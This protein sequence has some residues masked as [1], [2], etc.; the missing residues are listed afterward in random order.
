MLE[1]VDDG[2]E[3]AVEEGVEEVEEVTEAFEFVEESDSQ[4]EVFPDLSQ[5]VE[6]AVEIG[7][8]LP[9]EAESFIEIPVESEA[10][11]IIEV[12]QALPDQTEQDAGETVDSTVFSDIPESD[13]STKEETEKSEVDLS[14]VIKAVESLTTE[15]DLEEIKTKLDEVNDNL[16]LINQNY[17]IGTNNQYKLS[18]FVLAFV[19]AIFGAFLAYI[20]FSKIR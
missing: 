20:A 2:V 10:D 15:S 12:V 3:V 4:E 17:V 13:A 8:E 19:V 5:E 14:G 18:K 1:V 9:Q 6:E 7:E 16:L 11:G